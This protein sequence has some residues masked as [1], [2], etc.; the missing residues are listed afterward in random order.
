MIEVSVPHRAIKLNPLNW[1]V[2]HRAGLAA[3]SAAGAAAAIVVGFA[4]ERWRGL[5][6]A[7][8]LAR[9]PADALMWAILGALGLV[10][11][12]I[13]CRRISSMRPVEDQPHATA[14]R[15]PVAERVSTAA[16]QRHPAA[17][18]D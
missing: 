18:P 14:S 6:L 16:R 8:W 9:Y 3:A 2:E 4:I 13:Y 10:A 7:D 17:A 12:P 15:R 5:G 11:A 1:P